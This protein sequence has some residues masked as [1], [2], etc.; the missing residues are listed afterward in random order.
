MLNMRRAAA[1]GLIVWMACGLILFSHMSRL[2]PRYVEGFTPAVAA[3]LGIGIAW[4]CSLRSLLQVGALGSGMAVTVYYSERLLY[5][6]SATWW[7]AL[8]AALAAGTAALLGWV[9]LRPADA[10]GADGSA[11]RLAPGV[12]LVLALVAVLAVPLGADVTAIEEHTTDA[13]Y[14]GALPTEEQ[15]LVSA[16]LR[17]HQGTAR[18][19]VA[20]ESATQI[21]SL[22]VKDARPIVVLT[23]YNGRVFTTVPKL[24]ALIARGEVRFAFLNSYCPKRPSPTNA[25]CSTPAKWVRAHGQDVSRA[26][27]LHQ[28]KVLYL[29]PGASA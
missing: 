24:E 15:N 9:L 25:A 14:V 18:Y 19:Q 23:T 4:A 22:I 2:H 6:T 13:G 29:L 27:G 11:A 5:G 10:Q 7:I 28:G 17:A 1:A 12:A 26:A 21:G 16:Y 20:A 8:V 3:M